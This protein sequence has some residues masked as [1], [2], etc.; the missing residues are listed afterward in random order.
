MQTALLGFAIAIILALVTAL[1]GPYFVD[2]GSHRA[3][4]E[5]TASRLV[6]LD[7]RV[8]GPIDLRILPTPTLTLQQIAFGRSGDPTRTRAQALRIEFS[9]PALI[10][11]ELRAADLT[12]QGPELAVSV[13]ESGR[14][15]WSAPSIGF[16]PD[17]VSVDHLDIE[18]GRATVTDAV[19]GTRR[20]LDKLKFTGQV[21]SLRGPVKGRGS[22]TLD[23]R[24]YPYRLAMSRVGDDG[25]VKLRLNLDPADIART[26]ELDAAVWLDRGIPHFDG[27]VQW[28][29][30]AAGSL[31]GNSE[32]AVEGNPGA[33]WRLTSHVRGDSTAAVLDQIELQYGTDEQAVRLRGDANL[34][35]GAK[36]E[37]VATLSSP[38]ID[39]DRILALPDAVARR[40]LVAIKRLA[41]VFAGTR[42]LPIAVRLA[43]SVDTVTF[44]GAMLQRVGGDLT[45]DGDSWNIERFGL[46]APG[47]TQVA[48]SGRLGSTASGAAFA[49]ATKIES[50][51]PRVLAG[52]LADRRD[53]QLA[54]PGPLRFASDVTLGSE[55]I[56]LERL[57]AGLERMT[58][59]GRLDY[60][61]PA[62]DRPARLN[63]TLHSPQFDLDRAQA[64]LMAGLGDTFEW[65]REGTLAVDI[66][67]AMVGAT[68][69]TDIDVKL[70]RDAGGLDIERLAIGDIGGAKLAVAGRIDTDGSAP[71][72]AMTLDLDARNLDGVAGLL[73]KFSS[74]AADRLR[75]LAGRAVPA[76]LRGTLAV[77]Q[78]GGGAGGTAGAKFSLAG[79]A[80][81]FRID[82]QGD[83]DAGRAL[84]LPDLAKLGGSKIDLAG[85]LDAGDGGA[86]VELL[87]LDR[88]LAV[89]KR[90]GR[91]TF[92][93]RGP[94][95]GDLTVDAKLA[96]GG[97]D[98]S[99]NGTMR[100]LGAGA[101]D[102]HSRPDDAAARPTAQLAIKIAAANIDALAFLAGPHSAPL[103]PSTLTARLAWSD[104]SIALT[105]LDGTL[106][107]TTIKGRLGIALAQPAR[108]DGDLAIG[109]IDLPAAVAAVIGMPRAGQSG[110]AAWPA[111]PFERGLLGGMSGRIKVKAGRLSLASRLA[112]RDLAGVLSFDPTQ[113]AVDD[114]DGALAG[115]RI[116]GGFTFVRG[117]DRIERAKPSRS[118]RRRC[119]RVAGGRRQ[120]AAVG[121]GE[122]R[123]RSRRHRSKPGRAD[124]IAAGRR[125]IHAAGWQYRPLR[126][127]GVRAHH[128]RGRSGPRKRHG[129]DQGPGGGGAVE[130]DSA[131]RIGAGDDRGRYGTIAARRY[132]GASQRRRSRGGGQRRSHPICHGRDSHLVGAD[133]GECRGRPT[134]GHHGQPEGTDRCAQAPA[135]CRRVGDVAGAAVGRPEEQAAGGT[136][137]GARARTRSGR[138]ARRR[139]ERA[140]CD[141]AG[142]IGAARAAAAD[143][144][145]AIGGG[146]VAAAAA[147]RH[148][149]SVATASP[150]RRHGW[151]E[152]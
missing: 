96:A 119:G 137:G 151:D 146:S 25:A 78:D 46:R 19:S 108:V 17:A 118:R 66:G 26:A 110:D 125:H 93:A 60:S 76:K 102:G 18:D 136:A 121:T 20:V 122:H 48:F 73:E 59:D 39:L 88:L 53:V 130:W 67:R 145:A 61:W 70:R 1:V 12:L 38:Q 124:R 40:P 105:D 128:A 117:P 2:W 28:A 81:L 7:L 83:A 68:E 13:D 14:L 133:G 107:G 80:G 131:D 82:L 9:L 64:L 103:P 84:A 30:A 123:S 23:G 62:G 127:G 116:A 94:L 95:D 45:S 101:G 15:D 47:L 44:A 109:A 5:A 49:G 58:V 21:S 141:G 112:A 85:Q 87:G 134:S 144:P 79:N 42:H 24:P 120:A 32:G 142:H 98:A 43:I 22:F 11:G 16:D 115:G 27:T 152:S 149:S 113:L 92:N 106:A 71:R 75:R 90:T 55:K 36:P 89:D 31:A 150:A 100:L 140:S 91:L 86:L 65:P 139:R 35:F 6:G 129:A 143:P 126:S 52:W 72:G 33:P 56:V 138:F 111:E 51:D 10:G 57:Q 97:L 74:P 148:P 135:R 41:E 132:R 99:A 77:D 37:L 54:T 8:A 50:A 114:I 34:T 69:A 4:L 29:R 147:D 104:N 3:E 63:A